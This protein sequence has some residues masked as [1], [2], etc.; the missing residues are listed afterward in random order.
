MRVLQPEP[1]ISM[2]KNPLRL[3]FSPDIGA[4]SVLAFL[5]ALQSE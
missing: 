2:W 4:L 3:Y 5:I 1:G